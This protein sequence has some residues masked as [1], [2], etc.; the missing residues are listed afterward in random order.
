MRCTGF[1]FQTAVA[2]A[3]PALLF[4][5]AGGA[6]GPARFPRAPRLRGGKLSSPAPSEGMERREAHR[7]VRVLR[8][9][10]RAMTLRARLATLHRGV[11]QRDGARCWPGPRFAWGAP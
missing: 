6:G 4:C 1:I 11:S 3:S 5:G 9:A 10:A 2:N 8:D 7:T